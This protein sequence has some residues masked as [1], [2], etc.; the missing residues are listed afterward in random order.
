MSYIDVHVGTDLDVGRVWRQSGGSF[1]FFLASDRRRERVKEG[2]RIEV[3][4]TDRDR[5]RQR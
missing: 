1:E 3:I 5:D 4:E 2:I